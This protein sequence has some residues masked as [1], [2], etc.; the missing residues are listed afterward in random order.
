M[1]S[2]SAMSVRRFVTLVLKN[3][4]GIG[5]GNTADCV[6]KHVEIAL[7]NVVTG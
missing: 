3:V 1:Q 5:R 6:P 2:K 7:M 4:E